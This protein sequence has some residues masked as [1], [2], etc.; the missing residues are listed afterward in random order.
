MTTPERVQFTFSDR[1]LVDTVVDAVL[2]STFVGDDY[3]LSVDVDGI[4]Y[5]TLASEAEAV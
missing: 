4:T 1:E 5:P 3:D 2:V